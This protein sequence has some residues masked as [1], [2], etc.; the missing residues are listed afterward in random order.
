MITKYTALALC[1]AIAITAHA[2]PID[3]NFYKL[4]KGA[5]YDFLPT[6]PVAATGGDLASS[7]VVGHIFNDDLHYTIGSLTATVTGTY[8]G[9]VAAV[10]QDYESNWTLTR[11]AGL[12]VYHYKTGSLDTSDDNVTAGEKLTVSFNR[13]VNL[14]SVGL[15]ADG[16]NITGWDTG[17]KFLLNGVQ[18][19]LPDNI[20]S[21]TGLNLTGT[22]FTF[23]Y[24]SSSP[25]K[26]TS[27]F[28][29]A[30]LSVTAI[31]DNGATLALM[32]TAFL[33][34]AALRRRFAT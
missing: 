5:S 25:T 19:L 22:Q 16:H 30:S 1:S 28:Y 2:L 18:T 29:L 13:S 3:F 6:D 15:R 31:P 33:G 12:G 11:S 8:Y 21:I 9:N 4:G 14:S 7:N 27:Q 20:G 10:V 26:F 17:D 24:F 23:E 32:G 34:L